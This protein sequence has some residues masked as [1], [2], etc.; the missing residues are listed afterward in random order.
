[1]LK[2]VRINKAGGKVVAMLGDSRN[3]T[4]EFLMG[5]A[6]RVL[7]PMPETSLLYLHAATMAIR[8]TGGTVHLYDFVKTV[9]GS[10]PVDTLVKVVT[11]RLSCNARAF[12]VESGKIVRSVGPRRYQVVVDISVQ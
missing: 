8:K 7:L 5:R 6:D 4:E 2:N 3:L 1:M 9:R 10:D 12:R 11:H